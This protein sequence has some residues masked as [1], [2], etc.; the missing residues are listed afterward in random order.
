MSN[1]PVL[2]HLA[3]FILGSVLTWIFHS[4]V[5]STVSAELL[6]LH[7]KINQLRDE[8]KAKL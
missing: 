8:V 5:A 3:A 2:T 1:H 7:A 4:R 6:A